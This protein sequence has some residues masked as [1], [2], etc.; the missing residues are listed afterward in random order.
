MLREV[1]AVVVEATGE[2]MVLLHRTWEVEEGMARRLL[3]L[4]EGVTEAAIVVAEVE[5]VATTPTEWW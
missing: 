3:R 1:V 4:A 5:G 2:A